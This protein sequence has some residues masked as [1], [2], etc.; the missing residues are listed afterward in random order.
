MKR[1]EEELPRVMY[2]D[3]TASTNREMQALAD[4]GALA[5]ESVL[6]AGF[7]TAGRGQTGNV[8]ESEAGKNLTCSI[9]FYPA[10]LPAGQSFAIAEIAALSVKRALDR[11]IPGVTVKWP[12]DVYWSD[13][14]ICGILIENVLMENRITRSVIGIGL[15]LNQTVFRSDAPNPVSLAQITGCLYD[16]AEILAQ[17]RA[18]S[19][20]FFRQ[21]ATEGPENIHREYTGALYR[22]EGFYAYEDAGGRF[23][24]RIRDIEPSGHLI[25]ER[26]DGGQSRYAF[27]EVRYV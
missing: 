26:K 18:V 10:R 12:N 23:E 25:L 22:R 1:C 14:K 9:L 16:P 13:L 21:L 2:L 6:M 3:E 17:L 11:L 20:R 7:Q 8:W 24:A 15:N 4:A 5:D 27:K 19:H